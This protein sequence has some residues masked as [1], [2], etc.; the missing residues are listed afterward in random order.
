MIRPQDVP[1][2]KPFKREEMELLQNYVNG[3]LMSSPFVTDTR[4]INFKFN[5]LD[6]ASVMCLAISKEYTELGWIVAHSIMESKEGISGTI[7]FT[8]PGYE[9]RENERLN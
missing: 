2:L 5:T 3:A 7:S 8:M 1:V 9:E 4:K 6:E